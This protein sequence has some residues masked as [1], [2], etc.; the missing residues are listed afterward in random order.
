MKNFLL[1]LIFSIPSVSIAIEDFGTTCNEIK[2]LRTWAGGSDSYGI[3]AELKTNPSECE[4]G[5]YIPHEASNKQYV[6]SMLLAAKASNDRMCIQI[7]LL[8]DNI[9]NRCQINYVMHESI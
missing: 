6:F 3:W 7:R 2:R 5:F 4:G 8:S 1:V 9:S